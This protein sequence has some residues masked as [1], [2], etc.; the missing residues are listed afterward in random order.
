MF[1]KKTIYSMLFL[2]I[3]YSDSNLTIYLDYNKALTVAKDKNKSIFI[4]F[5]KK[6]CRW[7]N[8]LK[9]KL[10]TDTNI[11]KRLKNE[12]VLLYLDGI[13]SIFPKRYKPKGYPD[14]FLISPKEEIYTEIIGYHKNSKDYIKWFNYIK[15]EQEI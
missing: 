7:C 1:L 4:L 6:N 15:I 13:S 9:N 3:L 11:S 10:S 12:F 5:S 2:S 8:K 14:V